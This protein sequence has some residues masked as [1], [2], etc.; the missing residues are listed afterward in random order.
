MKERVLEK[1]QRVVKVA[2]EDISKAETHEQIRKKQWRV[3]GALDI[4]SELDILS[5]EEI[6]EIKQHIKDIGF[7]KILE[8]VD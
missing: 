6:D 1:L 7:E 3:Y 5:D 2:E 8:V 4:V